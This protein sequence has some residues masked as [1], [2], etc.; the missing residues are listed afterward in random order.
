MI[1]NSRPEVLPFLV[2]ALAIVGIVILTILGD[3]IPEVLNV[4]AVGAFA[5]GGAVTIPNLNGQQPPAPP[6]DIPTITD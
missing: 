4:V 5:T 1:V 6:A 2:A 3:P